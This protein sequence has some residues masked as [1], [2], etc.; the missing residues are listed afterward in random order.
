MLLISE[1]SFVRIPFF[2][3][4]RFF[5]RNKQLP[6]QRAHSLD[7]VRIYFF[8]CKIQVFSVFP[9]KQWKGI[10]LLG[11]VTRRMKAA[12]LRFNSCGNN[13]PLLFSS[14]PS[15]IYNAPKCI[16]FLNVKER[17]RGREA[18]LALTVTFWRGGEERQKE[19]VAELKRCRFFCLPAPIQ[20]SS[21]PLSPL[22]SLCFP[23]PGCIEM[24]NAAVC[25]WKGGP[26]WERT[27]LLTCRF[28]LVLSAL[29]FAFPF[30]GRL[31]SAD[32]L[33]DGGGGGGAG[34]PMLPT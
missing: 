29:V 25:S 5:P 13:L 11:Q 24:S 3:D 6:H 14:H 23:P 9:P 26:W 27:A 2:N 8:V 33:W 1:V 32:F 15:P 30:P 31:S 4:L 7:R 12:F 18:P 34:S 10:R 21:L 16:L 28:K 17:K 20:V 22:H 19:Q